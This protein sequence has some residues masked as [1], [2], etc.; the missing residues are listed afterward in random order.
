MKVKRYAVAVVAIG[1]FLALPT[2]A[3]DP[4]S[5]KWTGFYVGINGGYGWGETEL[6]FMPGG[7][8][9]DGFNL[10][11]PES[12][13]GKFHNDID[14]AIFG[15]QIGSNYQTPFNVVVGIEVSADWSDVEGTKKNP[16]SPIVPIVPASTQYNTKVRWFGT[17]TPKIG[18]ALSS[19]LPFNLLPYIKG[20]LVFGD[21][22]SNLKSTA[23]T[24]FRF[25]EDNYHVG[26]TI[27]GGVEYGWRHWIFGVEYNYYDLGT[28]QYGGRVA[29]DTTWP[30]DYKLHATFSS[31][32]MRVSYKFN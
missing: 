8:G 26:W 21:V 28:Q 3:A 7:S 27:G 15:G 17:A 6:R 22:E 18:Y 31:V 13:G 1:V 32:L 29:P 25:S 30:V 11:S 2:F 9:F 24:G 16:F 20:G 4:T 10:F 12:T 19:F 23:L 14:G 5:Q